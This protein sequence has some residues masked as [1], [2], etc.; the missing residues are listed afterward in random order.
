MSNLC[1]E[2]LDDERLKIFKRLAP[3]AK[4]GVLA[5]GTA[6]ALQLGHR[7]S[8]DFDI[9]V[10]SEITPLIYRKLQEVFNYSLKEP[11]IRSSDLLLTETLTNVEIHIVYV[12]YKRV[13]QTIKTF[14]LELESIEDIAADKANTI[15]RR[16]QWRDYVDLFFLLKN[17]IFSLQ[18]I[19]DLANKKY[20]GEFN[21]RLF[22]EQLSFFD[23]INDFAITFL[24]KSFTISEIQ[25]FLVDETKKFHLI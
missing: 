14:S 19:I 18:K 16:G 6:L 5:G 12:W 17:N 22:L 8:F 25:N 7:K 13:S 9:F 2:V 20:A 24:N 1:L 3:M 23:D 4:Y 15:G 21:N 10:P 11:R